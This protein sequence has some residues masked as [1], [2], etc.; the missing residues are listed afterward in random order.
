MTT[1]AGGTRQP[2]ATS[3]PGTPALRGSA[4][5]ASAVIVLAVNAPV[6][7][8]DW[9]IFDDDINVLVNP[10]LGARADASARW[11]FENVDYMRRYLPLGWLLFWALLSIAGYSAAVF[12]AAGWLLTAV[13]TVLVGLVFEEL[14][15]KHERHRASPPS[16]SADRRRIAASAL[17]ALMWTLHPLRVENAAWISGLLYVASTTLAAGAVLLFLRSVAEAAGTPRIRIAAAVC[18]LGSL[19]V[20]P[21]YLTLPAVLICGVAACSTESVVT[22]ARQAFR[23]TA[24]WWLAAAFAAGMNLFARATA[25]GAFATPGVPVPGAAETAADLGRALT[26]YVAETVS[27]C[28]I[29]AYYGTGE[30]WIGG[31]RGAVTGVL[32]L[33]VL[34]ALLARRAT[35]RATSCW[36]SAALLAL[37]PFL[38]Q[39]DG[40]FHPSDRYAVLWLAVWLAPLAIEL[41]R[42]R[43]ALPGP[44]RFAAAAAAL[45]A[46]GWS[47]RQTLPHWR[48]TWALQAS[49]DRK[50]APAPSVQFGFARA[51]IA[52]WWLGDHATAQR[53]L[54]DGATRFPGHSALFI[55]RETLNDLAPRWRQ[56]VG[57]R[58][59][60]PPLAVLHVDLGRTWLA[61]GE[62]AAAA[63]HFTRALR[64]APNYPDAARGL[65]LSHDTP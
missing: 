52:F 26:H 43:A 48:D 10:H 5:L 24:T 51:A 17:V 49:I 6:L 54:E 8:F 50:T 21:V 38:A 47:Y 62:R 56:R 30:S 2:S 61:R 32:F 57:A 45:L 36:S 65:V 44:V 39:R 3:A 64:L 60:T 22:A 19:L 1:F 46:L 58:V 20:Y 40:T 33:L 7:E 34:G 14:C 59:D 27:P 11:A 12:H 37:A 53:R 63:A 55:A 41:T 42:P 31:A 28:D 13:N 18:Y 25:S 9:L 4:L 16:E 23:H 35:R 29:A 15:R